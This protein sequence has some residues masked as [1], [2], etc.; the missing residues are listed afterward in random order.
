METFST[1]CSEKYGLTPQYT[2]TKVFHKSRIFPD[3]APTDMKN[4]RE[5]V[6]DTWQSGFMCYGVAIG[7]PT[8]NH[9]A[10]EFVRHKLLEHLQQLEVKI[11]KVMDLLSDNHQAAWTLI[12]AS[13]SHQLD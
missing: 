6:G 3:Q 4:A 12:S 5:M 7:T 11:D 9:C 2:K 8:V 1:A 10:P 13:L